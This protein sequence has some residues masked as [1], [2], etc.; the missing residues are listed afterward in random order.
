MGELPGIGDYKEVQDKTT[1]M[2]IG[3]FSCRVIDLETLIASKTFAGREKDKLNVWHLDA[4]RKR[5]Q[6]QPGLFDPQQ[7]PPAGPRNPS[8]ETP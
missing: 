2:N 7:A 3:G 6:K 4:I 1:Q 5:D 8:G